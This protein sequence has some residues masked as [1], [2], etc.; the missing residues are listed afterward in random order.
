MTDTERDNRRRAERVR[1][2]MPR[3]ARLGVLNVVL[4]DVSIAGAG[5][6][7]HVQVA[8][9]TV[10]PLVFRWEKQNLEVGCRL[11][12]SRLELFTRGDSSLRVYHSGVEFIENDDHRHTVRDVIAVRVARALDRQIADAHATEPLDVPASDSSGGINLNMLFP[13]FTPAGRGY[14]RCTY[15]RGRWRR[16]LVNTPDQP[17]NGFT[18]SAHESP[19]EIDLLCKTYGTALHEERRLIRIFA[20]LSVCEPSEVPHRAYEP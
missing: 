10:L 15:E 13:L 14:V 20:Q 11:V 1:L 12:R 19:E 17:E 6:Q 18:I 16:E 9:N 5:I 7:H 8:P 2:V 3:A 4:S